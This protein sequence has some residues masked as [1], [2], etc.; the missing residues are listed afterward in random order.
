MPSGD[1]LHFAI[2]GAGMS[3]I[4]AAIKVRE[5]GHDFTVFEKADRVGGTWRENTYP[6]IACDVPSHLYSYSFELNPDWHYLASPGEEIQ[7]YFEGVSRR[8]GIEDQIRFGQPVVRC[9]WHGGHWEVEDGAGFV[10]QYD[11]VI[12]ATGILHHPQMPDIEGLEDFEGALFHSARWDHSVPLDGQRIGV[13]GNGSTGVQITGAL[14]PRA[15]HFS[16]FQRTAQW[17]VPVEQV[18]YTEAQRSEFREH[19]EALEALH[20]QLDASF[21]AGFGEQVL[22]PDS[23]IFEGMRRTCNETLDTVIKDPVLREKLRPDY[24]PAC[25]R[26][27]VSHNFYESIQV[28]QAELVTEPIE[29]IE[30]GGVRTTDGRLHELDVLVCATGFKVDA[31]VRPMKVRGLDG[32]LLDDVWKDRPSAYLSVTVPGFPNFFMLNGP[33]SP[34]GNF[35]LIRTA[36][37]EC[38]YLMKLVGHVQETGQQWACPSREAAERFEHEREEAAKNTVWATGCRSW[39]LDDRGIPFVWPFPFGRFTNEMAK[40]R[41]EDYTIG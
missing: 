17:V 28:P 25:K 11:W 23:E 4:L 6:G 19:P 7:D 34:V 24:T 29:R 35:S 14:A 10:G 18:E 30:A 1:K 32:V 21:H 2:I 13:I 12:A 5:A 26:L 36:E 40:P 39:Y 16:L 31:F 33:N 37:M 22:N 20:E 38:D 9:E 41:V 15:G 27:V 8:Y 3:G